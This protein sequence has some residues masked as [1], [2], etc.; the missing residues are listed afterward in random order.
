MA[1]DQA[2]HYR[3]DDEQRARVRDCLAKVQTS[4]TRGCSERFVTDIEASIDHFRSAPREDRFREASNALRALWK[5]CHLD[6]PP[7]QV[8]REELR[9]LPERAIE[10]MG[11][12]ARSVIPQLFP[13][14]TID[15]DIFDLP[16]RLA[17][18][19]LAWAAA[20]DDQK[21]VE[22][23]RVLSFEGAHPVPGRSRGG[24]KRSHARFE[25]VIMGEARGAGARDH[26]GG[27]P[28]EDAR[29]KLVMHLA[30]AWQTATNQAPEAGRSDSTGFGDLV[31][32]IFQWLD[33]SVDTSEAATYALR[34]Y[35]GAKKR[36]APFVIP[37]VC[38]E[39]R[40]VRPDAN[41]DEPFCDK[42][43]LACVTAREAEQKCGPEGLLFE[44]AM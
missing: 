15:E 10:Y 13:G 5:R 44:Q 17:A 39:C 18:R 38:T 8:L 16:D 3:L 2:G 27:R 42:L 12:R 31:H 1:T 25:P 40:W 6:K 26:T 23:L 4:L 30:W 14:E 37:L 19:L 24:G 32:S 7:V 29:H 28:T 35:W 22:A 21:F 41:R 36:A 34:R 9:E 11:R 20:A 43:G 33:V